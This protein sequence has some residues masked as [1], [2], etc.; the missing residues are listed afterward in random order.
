M[1]LDYAAEL[2]LKER[3]FAGFSRAHFAHAVLDGLVASPRGRAYRAVTKRKVFRQGRGV[4]L[5]LVGSADRPA[6]RGI[7]VLRCAIEPEEHARIYAHHGALA[8]DGRAAPLLESLTYVVLKGD[9]R[10]VSVIWNVRSLAPDVVRAANGCSKSLTREFGRLISG[11]FLYRGDDSGRYYLGSRDPAGR[12]EIRKVFGTPEITLRV[13]GRLFRFP[14]LSFSQV[15]ASLLDLFVAGARELLRPEGGQALFDLYCGY[16]LFA[17]ALGGSSR[18]VIGVEA[19]RASVAAAREN[20]RR[21]GR[22][23]CRFIAADLQPAAVH[24]VMGEQA[25]GALAILD[26]PR[27]GAAAGVIEAVAAAGPARVL[28]VFC[29]SALIAPDLEQWGRKG[30]VP[31]RVRAYDMF[32]GTPELETMVLLERRR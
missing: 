15:N 32:P 5:G 8:R 17:L 16:G 21:L 28:H 12:Q 18:R 10:S 24:S 22:G 13:E 6:P 19:S 20:A 14:P 7:P 9:A 29:N 2:A 11:I 27:N 3:A 26:P 23:N 30:Y 1:T 31:A 25:R 4:R